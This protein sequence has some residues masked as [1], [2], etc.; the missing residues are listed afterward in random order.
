MNGNRTAEQWA[1]SAMHASHVATQKAQTAT[2]AAMESKQAVS[3]IEREVGELRTEMNDGFAELTKEIR[4][5]KRAPL[6]PSRNTFSPTDTGSHFIVPADEIDNLLDQRTGKRVRT[7]ALAIGTG[8]AT[9]G[10][11]QLVKFLL[12]LFGHH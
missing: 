10:G 5:L 7:M 3:L 1:E 2:N 9:L 8:A 12:G 6:S 11:E 4:T